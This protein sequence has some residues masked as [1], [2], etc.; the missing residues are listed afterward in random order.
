MPGISLASF[1]VIPPPP[2][3]VLLSLGPGSGGGEPGAGGQ[4]S[5][6]ISKGSEGLPR[7][8]CCCSVAQSCPTLANPWTVARQASLPMGFSRHVD[9]SGW[10]AMASSRGSSRPRDGT[11]V[12]CI[13]GRVL[14]TEPPQPLLEGTQEGF[15]NLTPVDGGVETTT[16]SNS[17]G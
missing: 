13:C 5:A 1:A 14:P 6:G 11:K 16:C 8:R 12:S 7:R 2:C 4:D 15:E 17:L 10:V 3:R 9:W